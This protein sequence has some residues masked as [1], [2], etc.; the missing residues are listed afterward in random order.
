M[1][2]IRPAAWVL[3]GIVLAL[4]FVYDFYRPGGFVIDFLLLLGLGI[5]WIRRSRRAPRETKNG[6]DS[7]P[8]S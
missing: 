8:Q 6:E 4:N 7:S 2:R 1:R 5:W 3:I